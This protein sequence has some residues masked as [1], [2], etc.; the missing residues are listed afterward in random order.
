ME[1]FAEIIDQL[2]RGSKFDDKLDLIN[3]ASFKVNTQLNNERFFNDGVKR[4]KA[5]I[6][7]T[8]L[9]YS[10]MGECVS[11]YC[12]FCKIKNICKGVLIDD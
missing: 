4:T 2:E 1:H 9:E 3:F 10:N 6:A 5:L 7:D 11:G 8:P 12:R